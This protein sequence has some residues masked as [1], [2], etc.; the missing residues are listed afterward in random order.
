MSRSTVVSFPRVST[1]NPLGGSYQL[2]CDFF[3]DDSRNK[4]SFAFIDVNSINQ[5]YLFK[6]ITRNAVKNIVDLRRKPVFRRPS[7]VHSQVAEYFYKHGIN[8]TEIVMNFRGEKPFDFRSPETR[9]A[10]GGYLKAGLCLFLYDNDAARG[11]DV[12]GFRAVLNTS[13]SGAVEMLPRAFR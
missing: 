13:T 7:F 12:D 4:I 9:D 8:Y 3:Q 1:A 10:I 5:E 6:I 2:Q 11:G